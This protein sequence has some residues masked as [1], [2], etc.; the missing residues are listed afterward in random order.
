MLNLNIKKGEYVMIGDNIRVNYKRNHGG[1]A[2]TIGITAPR[3]LQVLRRSLY[4]SELGK[5]AT[6]GNAEAQAKA[7]KIQTEREDRLLK[8][9]FR[10]AKLQQWKERNLIH[11]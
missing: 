10:K 2:L 7:E 5:K 9:D 11:T 3:D 8:T 1:N 6:E 4:E